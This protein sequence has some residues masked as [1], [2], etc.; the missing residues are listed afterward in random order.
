MPKESSVPTITIDWKPDRNDPTP[1]Y[2]Q[3][4]GYFTEHIANGDWLGGQSVPSQRALAQTFGVNRST[5]VEAMDELISMGMIETGYGAGTRISEDSWM[6]IIQ[7]KTPNWQSYIGSS[8]FRSNIPT[9]QTINRLEF[10]DTITRMS[11]GDISPEL[12]QSEL[13]KQALANLSQKKLFLNYP[14]PLG[15]PELRRAV[16]KRLAAMG[17]DVPINCILIVSGA[18]Q[19]LQLISTGVAQTK[20]VVYMERPSYLC[21]LNVF[22][23]AG[24][25][26][27]GVPMDE[28]GIQPW[29]IP[30]HHEESNHSLVYTIPTFQ[31]PTGGVMPMERR[32]E[33]IKYCSSHHI[34]IIE[35]DVFCDLWLDNPP[36][37][38]LKALDKSGSVVYIGSLSKCFSPGLRLGWLVGPE[39]IVDRLADVKMQMDYGVSALPQQVAT[40]LMESGLYDIGVSNIREQLRLRRDHMMELLER[41][42]SD[43]AE[44]TKPAGGFFVWLKLKNNVTAQSVFNE[45]LRRNILLPP[46][47]IYDPSCTNCIRL[48]YGYHSGE[49]LEKHI[50]TL[51]EIVRK[52]S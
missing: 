1:L 48:T 33:L 47:S 44:W 49:E 26:L 21:S 8:A 15:M 45:A 18:L 51:S 5:I 12:G 6:T 3:I 29:K 10:D 36:P 13:T 23:S 31:N 2:S 38:P 4:V 28:N 46:G 19:A 39:S 7:S 41:H 11:T 25:S 43:I 16:Q 24:V 42:F 50:I 9:V 37:P 30:S 32:E 22:Q 35:D 17:I 34:P 27:K 52:L 14:H 40:E 20:G